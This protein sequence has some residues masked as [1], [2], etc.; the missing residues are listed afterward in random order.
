MHSCFPPSPLPLVAGRLCVDGHGLNDSKGL[1][2]SPLGGIKGHETNV[3]CL[4]L[5]TWYF[6][7]VPSKV[8][9][10]PRPKGRTRSNH[11]KK[12]VPLN[13]RFPAPCTRPL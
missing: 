10:T 3:R 9:D 11:S 5:E 6:L 8:E 12:Q 13:L 4:A 2:T 7:H 1:Y